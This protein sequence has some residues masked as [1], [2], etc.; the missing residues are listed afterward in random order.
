MNLKNFYAIV[1]ALMCAFAV[2]CSQP[3]EPLPLPEA[4]ATSE[5]GT[6]TRA[7][8]TIVIDETTTLK[9]SPGTVLSAGDEEY[10]LKAIVGPS[11]AIVGEQ[12]QYSIPSGKPSSITLTGWQVQSTSSYSISDPGLPTV[13]VTFNAQN[14]YIMLANFS[15][16]GNGSAQLWKDVDVLYRTP[17]ISSIYNSPQYPTPGYSMT[18]SAIGQNLVGSSLEYEWTVESG[19]TNNGIFYTNYHTYTIQIPY[20]FDMSGD[21]IVVGC[22]VRR[23]Q[24][25]WS[26]KVNVFVYPQSVRR[27]PIESEAEELESA[28]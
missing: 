27:A 17:S 10:L 28:E 3:T 5:T 16:N 21:R 8:Q 15:L 9:L 13:N 1:C 2:A 23:G 14:G 4:Q 20:N 24:G 25:A 19:S 18:F 26:N 22:R 12:A 6:A 11:S 7:G